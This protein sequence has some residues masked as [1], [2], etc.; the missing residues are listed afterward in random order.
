MHYMRWKTHGDPMVV[1]DTTGPNNAFFGK[2]HT[3]ET[4]RLLSEQRTG[5][6]HH[7]WRGGVATLPYGPGF[8][9]KLKRL[10]RERD[11]DRCVR[12]GKSQADNHRTLEVHHLDHD[13]LNNDPSNLA[14]SCGS[15]N[16]WASWHRD[17]PWPPEVSA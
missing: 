15:C 10:I 6:L 8:T 16:V 1:A 3:E 14:T 4:K 5:P 13:K 11:G 7:G 9:R 2:S 12:C 17:E